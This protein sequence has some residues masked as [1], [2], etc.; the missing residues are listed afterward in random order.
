MSHVFLQY[1]LRH[2]NLILQHQTQM[3]I[4]RDFSGACLTLLWC[5][6]TLLFVLCLAVPAK[7]WTN[8]CAPCSWWAQNACRWP[9]LAARHPAF[10]ESEKLIPGPLDLSS[11]V[12]YHQHHAT[13]ISFASRLAHSCGQSSWHWYYFSCGSQY[14]KA[15][16]DFARTIMCS[17]ILIYSF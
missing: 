7:T 15:Q 11:S 8:L 5:L 13:S 16:R 3:M 6:G 12:L 14:W 17:Y 10:I 4:L 2:W 1:L 9:K